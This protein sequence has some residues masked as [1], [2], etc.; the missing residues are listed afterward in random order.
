M[1]YYNTVAILGANSAIGQKLANQIG[2]K[3]PLLLMDSGNENLDRLKQDILTVH[4]SAQVELV[5]CSKDASWEADTI[6]IA[7]ET[8]ADQ[9]SIASKINEVTTCK[10]VIQIRHAS[11]DLVSIQPLLPYSKFVSV[12]WANTAAIVEGSDE[13]S[14]SITGEI[15]H[16]CGLKPLF[17]KSLI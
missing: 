6:I 3:Y 5:A 7:A 14:L 1:Q 17:K 12:D 10:T 11:S 16:L 13:E 2:G 8:D 15:V 9:A 4:P